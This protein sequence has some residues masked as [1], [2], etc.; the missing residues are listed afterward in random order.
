MK[1]IKI[2]FGILPI[3]LFMSCDKQSNKKEEEENERQIK[4]SELPAAVKSGIEDKFPGAAL[5]EAD[6]IT[7]TDGSLTY[8][9]EIKYNNDKREVMFDAR[10]TYLGTEADDDDSEDDGE[11]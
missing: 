3:F 4:I 9:V 1:S 8:D 6:E 5:K 11:D 2:M 10:G 7:K